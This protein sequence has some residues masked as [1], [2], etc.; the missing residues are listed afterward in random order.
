MTVITNDKLDNPGQ[1]RI[2]FLNGVVADSVGT[3]SPGLPLDP[4]TGKTFVRV[5]NVIYQVVSE[6]YLREVETSKPSE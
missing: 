2:E 1:T 5:D 6:T 3:I 4:K